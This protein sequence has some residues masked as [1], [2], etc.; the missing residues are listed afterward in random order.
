MKRLLLLL[1]LALLIAS[2]VEAAIT[3][4][5]ST[6]AT[7]NNDTSVDCARPS[8]AGDG[9][10]F[11]LFWAKDDDPTPTGAP[12][13]T[14]GT[15]V[16]LESNG[17]TSGEHRASG[18]Y[19]MIVTDGAATDVTY[20]I[21]GDR[22]SWVCIFLHVDGVDT[23][24]PEDVTQTYLLENTTT[25][26][27]AT[28]LTPANNASGPNIW[29][30]SG[31]DVA[32]NTMGGPSGFTVEETPVIGNI[33]TWLGYKANNWKATEADADFSLTVAGDCQSYMVALRDASPPTPP[34][35]RTRRIF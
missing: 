17:T 19:R 22:E 9:D 32:V 15:W 23:T 18:I 27:T 11:Y 1:L 26:P 24:T 16:A 14:G 2:P 34:V 6:T 5:G 10:I 21:S 7:V 29:A 12:A 20:T 30:F 28:G 4:T 35:G 13:N 8:I 33:D 25:A 31:C 3:V